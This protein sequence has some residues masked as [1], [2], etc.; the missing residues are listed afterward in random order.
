MR[1]IPLVNIC[2]NSDF[3]FATERCSFIL[4]AKPDLVLHCYIKWWKGIVPRYLTDLSDRGTYTNTNVL[5][6][7]KYNLLLS[8]Q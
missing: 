1:N 4:F 2:T 5:Q 8:E 7:K 3:Q 6:A